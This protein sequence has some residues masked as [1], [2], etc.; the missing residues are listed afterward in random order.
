MQSACNGSQTSDCLPPGD[1]AGC[2]RAIRQHYFCNKEHICSVTDT[3]LVAVRTKYI[4]RLC[5]YTGIYPSPLLAGGTV[6]ISSQVPV[7]QL[8]ALQGQQRTL[9]VK[10]PLVEA[11]ATDRVSTRQ[12]VWNRLQVGHAR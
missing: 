3:P 12:A 8:Q 9:P 2:C 10:V 5:S 11:L 6:Q 7:Q 1:W 4:V